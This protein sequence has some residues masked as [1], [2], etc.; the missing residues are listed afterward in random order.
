M[1]CEKDLDC[2]ILIPLKDRPRC[3]KKLMHFL[4][5]NKFPYKIII[6]DGGKNK[7]IEKRLLNK[8]NYKNLDYEYIRYPFDASLEN[9]YEKMSDSV[10]RI[11]T[12]NACLMD[13]DDLIYIDGIKRCLTILEESSFSSAR[14]SIMEKGKNIYNTYPQSIIQNNAIERMKDQTIHFHGNWHNVSRTKHIVATWKLIEKVR[15]KNFRFVEQIIGYLLTIWGNSY[16]GEFHYIER[17]SSERIETSDGKLSNHFPS[18]EKWIKSDYWPVEF[19]KLAEVIAVATSYLDNIDIR[20]SIRLF[21]ETYPLKTPDLKD[22]LKS[23]IDEASK[24]GYDFNR[25]SEM[26]QILSSLNV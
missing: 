5:K 12:S 4:N 20:E 6:A 3:T 17:Y 23:R 1:L 22:L 13:N 26:Y 18:Q 19:N 2:T 16:R 24:I 10:E 8:E 14:G 21:C 7:G 15:P 11:K 9:F 25:I